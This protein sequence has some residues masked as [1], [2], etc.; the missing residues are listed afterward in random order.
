MKGYLKCFG[1]GTVVNVEAKQGQKKTYYKV[2]VDISDLPE[3]VGV[4]KAM[5]FDEVAVGQT[6]VIEGKAEAF[7]GYANWK[8]SLQAVQTSSEEV[9]DLP[10]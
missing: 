6:V 2:E 7:N 8:F 3:V 9:E 10:F 4:V 5:T 1:V